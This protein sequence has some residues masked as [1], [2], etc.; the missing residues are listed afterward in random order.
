MSTETRHDVGRQRRRESAG[1]V[2]HAARTV[3]RL[4]IYKKTDSLLRGNIGAEL[5]ALCDAAG[6]GPLVFAPGYPTGGRTTINGI[7]RLDGV[8]VA[9]AAPGRDPLTPVCEAHIPTLLR[10]SARLKT[11]SV[12][13]DVVRGGQDTFLAELERAGRT[14]VEVPGAGHRDRRRLASHSVGSSRVRRRV[15]Q[16]GLGRPRGIPGSAGPGLCPAPAPGAIGIRG[17]DRGHAQRPYQRA[18]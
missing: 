9:D 15:H 1:S 12:P 13:L 6:S 5:R 7:H 2:P 11:E 8:P 16:R 18:D 10:D 17:G 3:P 14:G 4:R